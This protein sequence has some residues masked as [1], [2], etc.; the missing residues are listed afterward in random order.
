MAMRT[1]SPWWAS[2]AFAI[3]LVFLFVGERAFAH[4]DSIAS[5]ATWLGLAVVLAVTGLRT[6]TMLGSKGARRKVE[7]ALLACQAG[8]LLAL[9]VYLLST[10]TGLGWLGVDDFNG[11][12][13]QKAHTILTV[14]WVL[15]MMIALVPLFMVEL[16]LGL[17]NRGAI[18]RSSG[19][20]DD[21]AVEYVRVRELAQSGLT[22]ALA[23]ALLMATCNVAGERN[24]RRDVSYFKTSSPGESTVNI[25]KN[26]GQPVRALL[27]FPDVNEV[28]NEVKG[29]FEALAAQ[30]GNLTVE[31]HDFQTEP[32][33]ASK[34]HVVKDGTVV[35]VRGTA[36]DDDKPE[37]K[38][39][40]AKPTAPKA[41][42]W[43]IDTKLDVARRGKNG[44]RTMDREINQRLL[45][46][47]RERRTLYV[48]VGHGE[49]NDPD[50]VDP[51]LKGTMPVR[52]TTVFK[53]R[54]GQLNYE[55]KD[56]GLVQLS[57]DVPDDATIVIM[58]APTQPL[59]DAELA[60]LDRYVAKGGRLL[61]ALDPR[62]AA[63]LGPLESRLG[64][65]F[66]P[67]PLTDD[68][69]FYPSSRSKADHR[70]VITTQFSA[71]ASTTSLSRAAANQGLLLIDAG[72][73]RDHPFGDGAAPKRTYVIRSSPSSWLDTTSN[74]EFDS[75]E[76]RD[77]YNL[78]AAI[79]G[80]SPGNGP[81]GKPKDGFRAFVVSDG[82]LFVD[83]QIAQGGMV[84][85]EMVSGPLLDDAI[86]W[87][88]GE[89]SFA[90]DVT[91][92][93]DQPIQHTQ[94]QDANWFY[95]TLV[96][97]PLLVLIGGLV[98]TRRRYRAPR[99]RAAREVT[100]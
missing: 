19:A 14:A 68:K 1:A 44:L 74:F 36:A 78:A 98:G 94:S 2:L 33:L 85:V 27:F 75:G 25:V 8:A 40:E 71:H 90:G 16:S 72:T 7:L 77:R 81:D 95:L 24:I 13:G 91:S 15:I 87:L 66:D 53:S 57:Q 67:T 61:V 30:S 23:A 76:K 47:V 9:F 86:K 60:A 92:E 84:F 96:G 20:G 28:G 69:M 55:A 79:E 52:K 46:L 58:L 3:G 63:T 39:G 38:P 49:L 43:E 37:P 97:A 62:G 73:L 26:S 59:K 54:I 88:G 32:T 70:W 64:V 17:A 83:L 65:T 56:L 45:K 51:S 18:D 10:K 29:Y 48:T 5:I 4:A 35:L 11:K 80:P 100:P 82:D 12:S 31:E 21:A 22:I 41:Q 93:D 50:S 99:G 42:T 89:E 6:W 34:Y